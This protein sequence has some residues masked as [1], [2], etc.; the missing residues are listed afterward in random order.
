[1][2]QSYNLIFIIYN[3]AVISSSFAEYD[4]YSTKRIRYF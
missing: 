4:F 3:I 2:K 1:M